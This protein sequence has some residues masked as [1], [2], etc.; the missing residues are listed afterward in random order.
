MGWFSELYSF[1]KFIDLSELAG[2]RRYLESMK[3]NMSD[4][5]RIV[6][7]G[8]SPSCVFIIW[9]IALPVHSRL[10]QQATELWANL[11]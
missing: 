4:T 9:S 6:I 7:T 11:T 2:G 1:F 3:V 10:T 5:I 8:K